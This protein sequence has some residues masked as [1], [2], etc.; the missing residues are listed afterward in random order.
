MQSLATAAQK[1]STPTGLSVHRKRFVKVIKDDNAIA[2]AMDG[3][4]CWRDSVFVER[5]S[6][7]LK[8]EEVYLHAYGSFSKQDRQSVETSNSTTRGDRVRRWTA[9]RH[10]RNFIA[11]AALRPNF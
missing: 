5:F 8:Y 1:S 10:Q 9:R 4:G 3:K 6:R 7:P 2:L 11:S